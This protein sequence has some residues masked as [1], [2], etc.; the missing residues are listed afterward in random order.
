MPIGALAIGGMAA[1]GVGTVMNIIGQNRLRQQSKQA[2]RDLR[3]ANNKAL[4]AFDDAYA[5]LEEQPNLNIDRSMYDALEQF[6]RSEAIASEGRATGEEAMRD[7][8]RQQ[9]ADTIGRSLNV[10][11][12]GTDALGVVSEA[13]ANEANQMNRVDA[14][15]AQQRLQQVAQGKNRLMG[16]MRENAA[17]N[18]KADL[19]EFQDRNR[20]A[21][22]LADLQMRR[23]NMERGFT[24]DLIS[25]DAA[26][27]A[28]GAA[29]WGTAGQA[30]GAIGG[31]LGQIDYQN[32]YMDMMAGMND[33]P[34]LDMSQ[35]SASDAPMYYY[36]P[37]TN[38][39]FIN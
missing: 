16:A 9:T 19:L 34:V 3:A 38:Y 39:G 13:T 33:N 32:Q 25:Q 22:Q 17:F 23:A 35:D 7:S 5:Y 1:Q 8:V 18:Q 31:T 21:Q 2:G 36:D 26:T 29:M 20:R 24:T 15:V 27:A 28:A 10:A 14:Q 11:G 6:A 12:S 30:L 37:N 4:S